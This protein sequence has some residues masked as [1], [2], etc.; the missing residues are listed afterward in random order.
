MPAAAIPA[1]PTDRFGGIID[2]L[3]RAV[4]ARGGGR[5]RL[6]GP[7]VILIW[8][9]VRRLAAQIIALAA[10]IAAGQH[11]R[12][13]ARRPPRRP[14]APRRRT[15]PALPLGFAWLLALVPYEAAGDLS[16]ENSSRLR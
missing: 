1:T 7:L 4:A 12:Y 15:P 11:R 8:R 14:A 6:A 2:G 13:P 16:P 9:H 10:R 3:C 5:D